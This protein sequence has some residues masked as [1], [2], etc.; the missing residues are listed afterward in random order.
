MYVFAKSNGEPFTG[1]YFSKRFKRACKSAGIDKSIHFHSLR[2][3]FASNFAQKGIN[4]YTIK[5]LL[6]HS[7]ITTTEI[8][9]HLNMDSLKE[10]I[11]TLNGPHPKSL[12][13]V[14]RGTF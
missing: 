5:E 8:Y 2:H 3:S 11:E 6:G 13:L 9:S 14:R 4:L 7:S 10:A 12:S 1:D